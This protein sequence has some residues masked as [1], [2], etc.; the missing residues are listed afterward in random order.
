MFPMG[1]A[2]KRTHGTVFARPNGTFTA[3]I[4]DVGVRR[5]I[6]TFPTRGAAERALAA[7]LV[8]GPPPSTELTFGDYLD[9]WLA[10]QAL[11]LKATTAAR[12]RNV[13]Q[14][15]VVGHRIAKRKVRR[16]I[17]KKPRHS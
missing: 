6:G 14:R 15:Y 1:K 9:E 2:R 3:Q 8:E 11:T 17:R 5:S 4:T 12:N 7:S 10:D 16:D 13:I